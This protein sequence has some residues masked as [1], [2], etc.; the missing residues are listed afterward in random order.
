ML[1]SPSAPRALATIHGRF[2]R[3]EHLLAARALTRIRYCDAAGQPV[4]GVSS[5]PGETPPGLVPWFDV[6]RPP[7][8]RGRPI[9]PRCS[10]RRAK[11]P[12]QGR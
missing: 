4:W 3:P 12:S 11:I 6:P 2:A 8:A 9:S 5:P 7:A 10:R 1:R